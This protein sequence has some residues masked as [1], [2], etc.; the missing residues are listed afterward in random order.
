[1]KALFENLY[2]GGKQRQDFNMCAIKLANN[3]MRWSARLAKRHKRWK[4]NWKLKLWI[5]HFS[6]FPTHICQH[7]C[8]W[9]CTQF[10]CARAPLIVNFFYSSISYPRAIFFQFNFKTNQSV[11]Y[12]K[13]RSQGLGLEVKY[14][15]ELDFMNLFQLKPIYHIIS[16]V[17]LKK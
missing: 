3:G 2:I 11:L 12:V 9:M 10:F 1:M 4:L 14:N 13:N 6:H 15:W 7:F 5:M 16:N 8:A 17:A